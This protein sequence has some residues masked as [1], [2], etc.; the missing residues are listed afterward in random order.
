MKMPEVKKMT[1][2]KVNFFG[3]KHK[4]PFELSCCLLQTIEAYFDDLKSQKV[5][6]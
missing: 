6:N 3:K 5:N 2:K 4:S 1:P